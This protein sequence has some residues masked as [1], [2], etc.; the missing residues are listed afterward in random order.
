MSAV[1][2]TRD[3]YAARMARVV[4]D[5]EAA[6]VDGVLV[7]P[8]PDL[9]WLTGYQPTAI[10]ERLTVLVLTTDREPTLLVPTLSGR[11]PSA[12]PAPPPPPSST[13]S[14]APTRTPRRARCCVPT[15]ATRSPTAR[16]PCTC[17]L[18]RQCCRTRRT[19]R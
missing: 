4:A 16:G 5:G 8:G 12:P 18:S 3:D 1:P 9:V 7:T 11:T 15:V 13:G 19:T 14:T 6:G 10:T 17:W 2:F